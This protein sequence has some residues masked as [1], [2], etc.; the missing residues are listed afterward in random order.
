MNVA[1]NFL[2]KSDTQL[3]KSLLH[4]QFK[5]GPKLETFIV[6]LACVSSVLK[7]MFDFEKRVEEFL[8]LPNF[9]LS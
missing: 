9:T 5:I 3:G 6:P 1:K 2:K 7:A 4:R 8:T